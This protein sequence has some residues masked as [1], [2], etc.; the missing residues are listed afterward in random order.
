MDGFNLQGGGRLRWLGGKCGVREALVAELGIHRV[1]AKHQPNGI[2]IG[3]TILLCHLL[4]YRCIEAFL[5][6]SK[7]LSIRHIG[8]LH[9]QLLEGVDVAAHLS[10]SLEGMKPLPCIFDTCIGH[11]VVLEGLQKHS[12]GKKVL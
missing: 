9:H 10:A 1:K 5:E 8:D 6:T 4:K 3:F 12:T 11:E 7:L 2:L